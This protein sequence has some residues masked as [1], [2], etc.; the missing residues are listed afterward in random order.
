MAQGE[1]SRRAR[2]T[3]LARVG[4]RL[5]AVPLLHVVETMRPLAIAPVADVP[6][7]V[8]GL[9]VIRGRALPVVSLATLLGEPEGQAR[10]FLVVRLGVDDSRHVAL[11]VDDVVGVRGLQAAELG[12]VSPLTAGARPELIEAVGTLD[13]QLLVLLRAARLLSDDEWRTLEAHAP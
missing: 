5:C 6:S 11:L 4:V 13:A 8:R 2:W 1:R 3:V 9:A 12:A 10:R 7:F